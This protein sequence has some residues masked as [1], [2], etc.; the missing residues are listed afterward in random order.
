MKILVTEK[1]ADT[2]L[3]MLK[4]K[5]D[6]DIKQGM[7]KDQLL[8]C[9]GDYDALI[10]RS[11]TN[12][13]EDI[14]EKASKLKVIGR[15]GIGVDNIDLK[16]ATHKGIIVVNTPQSNN[17]STAEHAVALLLCAARKIPQ[18]DRS[19]RHK[20]WNRGQFK[21]IEINGKTVAILGL[22]RIGSIVASRIKCFGVEVIGYDPY[23]SEARFKKLGVEKVDSIDEI[24]QRA[25]FIS[26]HLPKTEETLG[27]IGEKEL[28]KAKKNLIIV[29]CARGG[30]VDEKA[31]CEALEQEK[32]AG[33]ALDGYENEPKGG[34]KNFDNPLLKLDN[35][36]LTPH[37]GASTKEAQENVGV[38]VAQQVIKSLEGKFVNAV[39][40]PDLAIKDTDEMAH[41]IRLG[42]ILG[43]LYYQTEKDPVEKVEILY[44]G[45]IS[46]KQTKVITLSYLIG[47]LEPILKERVNFVN[48][49]NLIS[50][51][52][53][54]VVESVKY[55]I[56]YYTNLVSVKVKNKKSEV[57]FA[58]TVFGRKE[59]RI[60]NLAGF[61]VD[62]VPTKYM[63]AIQNKDTPGVIGQIGTILGVC[64]TNIATMKVSRNE[65]EGTAIMIVNVDHEVSKETIE[66]IKNVPGVIEARQLKF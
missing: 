5:F 54:E 58:G 42:E 48:I 66:L 53:I 6:T 64:K 40:L 14:I 31:L 3:E 41:Y 45:E 46:E 44:S 19:L 25:D 22:G 28:E 15:A 37:L 63:L 8:D 52:G 13:T 39:N 32:I 26:L 62:I 61:D 12:V 43:K 4:E 2:G 56:D 10:V 47:L 51:R 9:I 57:T 1:I 18:A 50:Q 35:V 29:N 24:M 55:N 33:A 11:G 36:V 17:I 38:A 21:G 65:K 30:L 7:S 27:I 20:K 34:E 23:I 16:A 59:I 60:V 49:E